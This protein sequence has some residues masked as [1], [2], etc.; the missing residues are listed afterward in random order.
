MKY[1]QKVYV[2]LVFPKEMR[3]CG[4]KKK[5]KKKNV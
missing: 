1:H 3:Q 4:E 2:A 5:K